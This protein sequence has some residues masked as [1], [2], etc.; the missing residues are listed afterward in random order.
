MSTESDLRNIIVEVG[1]RLYAKDFVAANDGN[2]SARITED[3]LL[4][5]PTGVSKGFMSPDQIIKV[6]LKG[7]VLSGFMK[8]TTEMKMHLAVYRLRPGIRAVVHAHPPTA[9]GFAVAGVGFDRIT[10]PEVVFNLGKIGL[11]EYAT[12]TTEQVPA[13]VAK[14]ICECDAMLLAN[15]GALTVGTDLFD[16]YYKMET[17]EAVAKISLVAKL[18]GNENA[19][20]DAQ[21]KELFEIRSRLRPEDTGCI[22]HADYP[23]Q[24]V[25][26]QEGGTNFCNGG[27]CTGEGTI[28]SCQTPTDLDRLIARITRE[29][30]PFLSK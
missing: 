15:H 8:P 22:Q 4:I 12:P 11:S 25:A 18:L 5:T 6:N 20:T 13:A 29:M 23:E 28:G 1:R 17:L 3:E 9:T 14:K 16:A 30:L 27:T 2:I 19:L 21:Q 7:E 26:T 10:L 24:A